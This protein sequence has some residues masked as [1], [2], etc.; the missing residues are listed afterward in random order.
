MADNDPQLVAGRTAAGEK[1]LFP[2]TLDSNQFQVVEKN[3][4]RKTTTT[5]KIDFL[6]LDQKPTCKT[7]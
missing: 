7:S 3:R 1:Y 4:I 6:E 2:P 5:S